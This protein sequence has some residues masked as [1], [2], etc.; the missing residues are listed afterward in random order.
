MRKRY[1]MR[2]AVLCALFLVLTGSHTQA[3]NFDREIKE[4]EEKQKSFEK[5][6][7]EIQK[8][9]QAIEKVREKSLVYI[10]KLDKKTG[11]LEESLDELGK[12]ITKANADLREA[13]R[14]L[15]QAQKEE[16][17]QYITMKKRIKYMYENGNNEYWQIVFGAT[18][19]SNLLGRSEYVEK[20]SSYDNRIFI[21]YK[22]IKNEVSA[23]ESDMR[24]QRKELLE[25]ESE[26]RA[27]KQYVVQ[28]KKKKKEE[29]KKYNK[30]LDSSQK[31]ADKYIRQAI[32][33]ENKVEDLLQKK[34]AEIDREQGLEG[35][36]S[37]EKA[38]HSG[39]RWPLSGGAGRISSP[40]GPRKSPKAGASSYHR[41]VDLAIAS[42]TPIL[43]AAGGRIVTSTYSSSAGNYIMISHGKR[44]YTVYMHCSRRIVKVGDTVTKGQ[45]IGYVGST[46]ISTGAHL[47]FG[48]S[49]NGTYVNPLNYVSR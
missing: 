38:S 28:L 48:V 18:S 11:E 40:F 37:D 15:K 17:K 47:H 10:E 30:K 24:R 19:M 6:A 42:G 49:K 43:A 21:N 5:K 20:I 31:K 23:Q 27:E 44:L 36:K 13:D 33:A 9:M 3:V 41:G 8:E 4:E 22:K 35:D 1:I 32:A 7:V 45:V 29:I 34:Q 26:T 39:L 12:K 14:N 16:Q 25:L 2:T 46:G